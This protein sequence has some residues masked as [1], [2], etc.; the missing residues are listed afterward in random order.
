MELL[1]V[2]LGESFQPSPVD[3]LLGSTR[4]ARR[5]GKI[6]DNCSCMSATAETRLNQPIP[7]AVRGT[8]YRLFG[9]AVTVFKEWL[10]MK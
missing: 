1:L 9:V 3:S 10:Y 2:G 6:T 8:W 7:V 4:N 5:F